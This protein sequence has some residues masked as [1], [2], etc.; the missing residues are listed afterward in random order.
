LYLK[1][2]NLRAVW[3]VLL[4][5]VQMYVLRYPQELTKLNCFRNLVFNQIVSQKY[6]DN[7]SH[8]CMHVFKY[9]KSTIRLLQLSRGLRQ[10]E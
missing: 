2:K 5:S 9:I 3:R 7:L 1:T 10:G 6:Y 8:V 4:V